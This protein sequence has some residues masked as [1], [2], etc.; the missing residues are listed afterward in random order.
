MDN[1]IRMVPPRIEALLLQQFQQNG[2][3]GQRCIPCFKGPGRLSYAGHS[4]AST[5]NKVLKRSCMVAIP[6]QN[7]KEILNNE[8]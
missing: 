3:D 4:L 1:R 7:K 2:H 5:P 8:R 6:M